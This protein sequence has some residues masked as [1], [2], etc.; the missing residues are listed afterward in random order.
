MPVKFQLK[1]ASGTPVQA[2]VA[3]VWLS[4]QRGSAMSASIDESI[5]TAPATSGNRFKWDSILQ[6]YVYNWNTKGLSAGY[7]YKI[8][9]QL[10][11]GTMQSVVVG[12]K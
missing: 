7:W 12:L 3:P 10:D 5:Y 8:I 2:S 4:P 9:V 1:N 6:Q 11:D